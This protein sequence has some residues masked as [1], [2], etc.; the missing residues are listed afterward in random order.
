MKF[1]NSVVQA[2]PPKLGDVQAGIAFS[3]GGSSMDH[4]IFNQN[5]PTQSTGIF[6]R[7]KAFGGGVASVAGSGIS[8]VH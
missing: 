8:A 6:D 5:Q 2:D 1:L 4:S 7:A 3:Q